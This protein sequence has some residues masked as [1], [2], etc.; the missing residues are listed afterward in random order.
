M[1]SPCSQVLTY[2]THLEHSLFSVLNSFAALQHPF[3]T[4]KYQCS[5]TC[6]TMALYVKQTCDPRSA[7]AFPRVALYNFLSLYIQ[8]SVHY[9]Q[10][11]ASSV[12]MGNCVFI[13][14]FCDNLFI[15]SDFIL[16]EKNESPGLYS[17]PNESLYLL[18]NKWF[19]EENPLFR[20]S[21]KQLLVSYW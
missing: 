6:Q 18:Q 5:F 11:R 7:L 20:S 14:T 10:C 4:L 1:W 19:S 17:F 16:K 9:T 3:L 12:M 21:R 15:E 13:S 2:D 8:L